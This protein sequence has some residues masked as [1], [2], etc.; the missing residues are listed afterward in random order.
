MSTIIKHIFWLSLSKQKL[1]ISQTPWV[2]VPEHN[3]KLNKITKKWSYGRSM[4]IY[5]LNVLMLQS[6]ASPGVLCLSEW[7][8]HS[9]TQEGRNL[10]AI[11]ST[12]STSPTHF[13]YI[14]SSTVVKGA[15]HESAKSLP[16]SHLASHWTSPNLGKLLNLSKPPNLCNWDG[17]FPHFT[18]AMRIK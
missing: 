12:F 15:G 10:G 7:H 4:K 2:I 11:L 5:T 8:H 6:W 14:H 18:V 3:L 13:P 16:L 1:C 9:S 17:K